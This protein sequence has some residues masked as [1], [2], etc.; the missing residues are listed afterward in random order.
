MRYYI[1]IAAVS[2]GLAALVL[3]VIAFA[4]SRAATPPGP[5]PVAPTAAAPGAPRCA[6]R[7]QADTVTVIAQGPN[8]QDVPLDSRISATFSCPVDP[9]AVERAFVL[10]PA[11]K[12]HFEWQERTM[13]FIPDEP[14]RP[15]TLYRVTLFGGLPDARG[16]VDGRKVSWPFR[17]R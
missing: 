8:G 17:T 3:A 9:R 2:L 7:T 6:D 14:L 13:T 15:R 12:G 1:R 4:P 16:F 11:A 5:S 10:Y